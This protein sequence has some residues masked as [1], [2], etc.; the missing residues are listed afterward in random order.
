MKK[1]I[2]FLFGHNWSEFSW[3]NYFGSDKKY[4]VKAKCDFCGEEVTGFEADQ[5]LRQYHR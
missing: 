3:Q 1:I 4:N 5:I 2:C